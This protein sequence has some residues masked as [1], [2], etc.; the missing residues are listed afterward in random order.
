MKTTILKTLFLILFSFS[1]ITGAFATHGM[2]GEITWRCLGT[3]EFVFTMKFYRDCNGINAPSSLSLT[4]SV[5]G[6]TTIP[7]T[8]IQINDVSPDGY[9][10]NG[11]SPC[12]T[13]LNTSG[14]SGVIEE[15]IY[16]SFPVFL[17]GTPPAGGWE[18]YWGECCRTG[19]LTNINN[20]INLGF[21]L[22][23]VMYPYNGQNMNPCYDSSPFFI[24]RPVNVVCSGLPVT[25][26]HI[27]GDQEFDSLS[28]EFTE[29]LSDNGAI[30]P[31]ANGYSVTNPLPGIN[32]LDPHTGE[33]F[34]NAW[35]GGY[36]AVAI[37]VK[38]YKC[39]VLASE[40]IREL[41]LVILNSCQPIN[42]NQ[43]QPP[44]M[45]P[46][47]ADSTGAF[48][49][50]A[51]TVYAGDTVNFDINILDTDIFNNATGQMITFNSYGLQYGD[52]Y[53]DP[54][55][56][57]LIPPCATL[58]PPTQPFIGQIGLSANFN[59]ITA[60]QHLGYSFSCVQ[61]ANTY[62]FLNKSADNFCPA[63]ASS[64]RVISITVLPTIPQ[65]PVI[66]N[67]G[68]LECPWGANYTYQWFLERNAIPGATSQSYTPSQ[69]GAYR[70]LA[71]APDGNGNY[72]EPFMYNPVGIYENNLSAFSVHPNPGNGMVFINSGRTDE[73]E[74]NILVTDVS[75]R[76][77][78]SDAMIN[79]EYQMD[80]SR[81]GKGVLL[82]QIADKTGN[83]RFERL[84]VY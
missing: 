74:Y 14:L 10:P 9:F 50:Y 70:V 58:S 25:Y 54:T 57:C 33:F 32:T 76:I 62:Y 15:H 44:V 37:K 79:P 8:R 7:M 75:G 1:Q 83:R 64:S 72:S 43:N 19:A 60:P 40:N 48:T 55:S 59:W 24:E 73:L 36:Y 35:L 11:T 4:T 69:P 26:Q 82:L 53:S 12:P 5:P 67:L 81:F 80:L 47:F 49:M 66:N 30:I 6:V 46:P 34:S 27:A 18:F 56:G 78:Y 84:I 63:N 71:V 16:Q 17:N 2:G 28:Y 41:H 52:S 77:I 31:F 65:P 68:V 3:G 20:G 38:S 23:A 29:P 39:G 22:R 21:R 51:D 61:F 42:G 45:A 13:C